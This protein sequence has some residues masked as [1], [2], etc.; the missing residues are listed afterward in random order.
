M[1]LM[2]F[3]INICTVPTNNTKLMYIKKGYLMT[4]TIS[5]SYFFCFL[6]YFFIASNRFKGA[7]Y[8]YSSELVPESS[9]VPLLLGSAVAVL[10]AAGRVGRATQRPF[11]GRGPKCVKC[12][13]SLHAVF[14]QCGALADLGADMTAF[15]VLIN[16][17]NT[18]PCFQKQSS[19]MNLSVLHP[20]NHG[21]NLFSFLVET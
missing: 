4:T 11:H 2:F 13:G 19:S 18:N 14:Q 9:C 17:N 20:L 15:E 10:A 21:C 12:N 7:L 8:V 3:L 6:R 16:N 5:K 1:M